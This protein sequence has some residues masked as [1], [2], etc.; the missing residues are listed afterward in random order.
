M[1]APRAGRHYLV[2]S[3]ARIGGI[4]P[5]TGDFGSFALTLDETTAP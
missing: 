3:R 1:T 4:C 5:C 2:V